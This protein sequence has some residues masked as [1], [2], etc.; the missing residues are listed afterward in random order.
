MLHWN[1]AGELCVADGEFSNLWCLMKP[2]TVRVKKKRKGKNISTLVPG[3][4]VKFP[5]TEIWRQ[6][7]TNT[8]HMHIVLFLTRIGAY[9]HEFMK[10]TFW[11]TLQNEAY[12]TI[13]CGTLQRLRHV[14]CDLM[15]SNKWFWDCCALS[16][17]FIQDNYV[18]TNAIH[19]HQRNLK[20]R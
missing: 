13:I 17:S 3:L 16:L 9:Q 10:N 7:K 15:R 8:P 1:L 5:K 11:N 2:L 14:N 4:S 19:V 6:R 12:L 20:L 18:A